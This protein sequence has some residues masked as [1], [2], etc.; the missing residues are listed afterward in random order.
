M[1]YEQD[2]FIRFESDYHTAVGLLTQQVAAEKSLSALEFVEQARENSGSDD[3]MPEWLQ[4]F[5]SIVTQI[6]AT[7]SA[8]SAGDQPIDLRQLSD[9]LSPALVRAIQLGYTEGYFA[10]KDD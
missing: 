3:Y 7:H 9:A 6:I 4:P 10:G 8:V 2:P 1:A 5:V